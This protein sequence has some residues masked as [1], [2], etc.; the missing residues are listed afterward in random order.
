MRNMWNIRLPEHSLYVL[1][2]TVKEYKPVVQDCRY[3]DITHKL[4]CN[5]RVE[6]VLVPRLPQRKVVGALLQYTALS[7]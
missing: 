3:C 7:L 5:L 1:L 4:S 6:A 2:S